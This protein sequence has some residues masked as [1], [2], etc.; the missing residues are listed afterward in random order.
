MVWKRLR[1]V[2][3]FLVSGRIDLNKVALLK[4]KN[5]GLDTNGNWVGFNKK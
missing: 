4:L 5:R 1:S 2:D 3:L